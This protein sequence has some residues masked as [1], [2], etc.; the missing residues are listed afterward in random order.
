MDIIAR[1]IERVEDLAPDP[2]TGKFKLILMP[3]KSA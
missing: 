1:Q 3:E 2:K